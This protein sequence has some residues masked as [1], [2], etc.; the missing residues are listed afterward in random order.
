MRAVGRSEDVHLPPV[1]GP[2]ALA[3]PPRP[4]PEE[5]ANYRPSGADMIAADEAAD[6]S[7]TNGQQVTPGSARFAAPSLLRGGL[8]DGGA[9]CRTRTDE[10][11]GSCACGAS[12]AM[13]PVTRRCV[14]RGLAAEPSPSQDRTPGPAWLPCTDKPE[15]RESGGSSG[16]QSRSI[17]K[18]QAWRTRNMWKKKPWSGHKQREG[19][20][21]AAQRSEVE[22]QSRAVAAAAPGPR[23]RATPPH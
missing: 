1:A 12:A 11:G 15:L 23:A 7:G 19:Q 4:F 14:G 10:S 3:A 20:A 6:F 18:G 2:Y 22:Q 8:C 21:A 13:P 17:P 5:L 9:G 16:M